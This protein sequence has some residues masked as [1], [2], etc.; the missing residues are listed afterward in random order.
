MYIFMSKTGDHL[1]VVWVFMYV[2]FYMCV[3]VSIYVFFVSLTSD[4]LK[5]S[6][7]QS[8]YVCIYVYVCVCTY[9][10]LGLKGAFVP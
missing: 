1:I 9:I 6:Y 2:C 10:C 3:Y 4:Q 5:L 7:R 8:V